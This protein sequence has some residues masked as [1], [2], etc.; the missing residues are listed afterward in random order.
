MDYTELG[1]SWYWKVRSKETAHPLRQE[2]LA[3]NRTGTHVASW[4]S[5][6]IATMMDGEVPDAEINR[7]P[8]SKHTPSAHSS[9]LLP[10]FKSTKH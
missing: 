1:R 6:C 3:R 9:N 8:T 7:I 4:L 5:D 10:Y 2:A